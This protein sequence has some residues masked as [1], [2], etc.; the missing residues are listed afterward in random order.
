M[1]RVFFRLSA[2]PTLMQHC[3]TNVIYSHAHTHT[4]S[5]N[6]FVMEMIDSIYLSIQSCNTLRTHSLCQNVN[7]LVHAPCFFVC[8]IH[9]VLQFYVTLFSYKTSVCNCIFHALRL[10]QNVSNWPLCLA[11]APLRCL[12]ERRIAL[13]LS[14]SFPF[15]TNRSEKQRWKGNGGQHKADFG[16]GTCMRWSGAHCVTL[17]VASFVA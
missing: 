2:S 13:G 11:A 4:H 14:C 3:N 7:L 17:R 9:F 15:I 8:L 5:C 12:P 6:A 16:P 10:P 1:L